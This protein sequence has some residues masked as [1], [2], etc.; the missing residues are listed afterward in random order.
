MGGGG[1]LGGGQVT[2]ITR[3]RAHVSYPQVIHLILSDTHIYCNHCNE[4][5]LQNLLTY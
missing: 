2:T 4:T 5:M 1:P 3:G